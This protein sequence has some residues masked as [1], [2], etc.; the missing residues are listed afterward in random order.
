MTLTQAHQLLAAHPRIPIHSPE[1][2]GYQLQTHDLP[3]TDPHSELFLAKAIQDCDGTYGGR[4][5][6]YKLA[7]A[8]NGTLTLWTLP[9]EPEDY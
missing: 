7:E 4:K 2:V 9:P 6:P 8:P 3:P 1:L 5:L